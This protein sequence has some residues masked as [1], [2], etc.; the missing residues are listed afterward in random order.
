MRNL[1][2]KTLLV[3]PGV[4]AATLLG[5]GGV[6]GAAPAGAQTDCLAAALEAVEQGVTVLCEQGRRIA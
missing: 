4:A 5:A 3:L 1:L 2:R 6:A